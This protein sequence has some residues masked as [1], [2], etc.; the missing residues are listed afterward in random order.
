V[1]TQNDI[2][3]IVDRIAV[4]YAPLA[5]GVFGSYATGAAHERSDLDLFVIKETLQRASARRQ[6]VRRHIL[7]ILHPLDIHVFTPAEFE[8]EVGEYLSFAWIV[9]R[10]ARLYYWTDAAT[11]MVPSLANREDLLNPAWE[12]LSRRIMIS[13]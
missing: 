4:H 7:S 6:A 2:K 9:A 10:Q 12:Q 8:M 1:L 13:T 5:V 3:R 11:H